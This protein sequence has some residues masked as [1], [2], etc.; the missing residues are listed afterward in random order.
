MLAHGGGLPDPDRQQVSDRIAP[1]VNEG[2]EPARGR[3][4]YQQQCSKC[5]K[6]GAEGGQVGPDLTGMAAIPRTELLIHIQDPSRSVEGN[7]VQYTVATTDG[8]VISGL[9]ASESKTSVE[10]IDAEG[11]RHAILREDI[12]QM[13]ASKK[14]LMPEGFEKQVPP[15]GLNDLLAFLTQRGKYR[16]LDLSKAATI[17]STRGM[18][19]DL[20]SEPERLVFPD[21]SPKMVDGVPF[22]LVDP[23]GDKVPNV[24]LLYGPQGKFPPLMPKSV[25]LVCKS[26]AKA[27]HFL[28]GVSGWGYPYGRKGSVSLIVRLHYADGK[29]ED[30]R[31]VNGVHFADYIQVVDVPGSKLA[32]TLGKQQIRYFSVEPKRK[33]PIERIELVK[34]PDGSAP[35]VM[36]V[37]VEAAGAE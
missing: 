7:F 32:F 1:L 9:L 11:K 28:S 14:S 12:D 22:V 33:D 27:I 19:E 36:A 25:D 20:D 4:V 37:T 15:A 34:G 30:H 18:F 35:V 6:H 2:G 13:A 31:L 23:K 10:L 5:H 26:S 21:W 24:V 29:V 8:R 17:V 16:P 3:L